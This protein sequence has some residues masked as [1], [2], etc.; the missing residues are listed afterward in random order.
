MSPRPVEIDD[1]LPERPRVLLDLLL[2][3]V[4]LERPRLELR[5]LDVAALFRPLDERAGL[6]RL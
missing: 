5:R 4:E 2:V 6:I 1:E 3:E